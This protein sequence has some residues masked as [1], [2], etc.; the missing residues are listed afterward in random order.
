MNCC[1]KGWVVRCPQQVALPR[2]HSFNHPYG[3]HTHTPTVSVSR[4]RL[5]P[6]IIYS[7]A[8][9]GTSSAPIH[10][11]RRLF[12]GDQASVE[13]PASPP[14]SSRGGVGLTGMAAGHPF[15]FFCSKLFLLLLLLCSS[16]S[17]RDGSEGY[18]TGLEAE[19]YPADGK[20]EVSK[21]ENSTS[22]EMKKN[23]TFKHKVIEH[24]FHCHTQVQNKKVRIAL[25]RM[26]QYQTLVG[27]AHQLAIRHAFEDFGLE[28]AGHRLKC[29]N[30]KLFP[31]MSEPLL[32]RRRVLV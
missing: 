25:S 23:H 6:P 20:M 27:R 1:I 7:L 21:C 3:T 9:L 28:P 29:D 15:F 17:R 13:K 30:M 16:G 22:R 26:L 14:Q 8:C 19:S 18:T 11:P 31:P 10:S 32:R 4:S 5:Q 24:D 12:P 2:T